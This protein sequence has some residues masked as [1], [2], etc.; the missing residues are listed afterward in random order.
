M[1]T[2]SFVCLYITRNVIK[3]YFTMYND[4]ERTGIK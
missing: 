3:F 4:V 1:I 2:A